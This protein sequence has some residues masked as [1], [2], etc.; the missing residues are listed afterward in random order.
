MRSSITLRFPMTILCALTLLSACGDDDDTLPATDA[1]RDATV[2]DLGSVDLSSVDLGYAD[3]GNVDLG[4]LDAGLPPSD[5]GAPSCGTARPTLTGVRGT[6]GLVIARDGTIYYS[7]SGGVGRVSIDGTNDDNWVTIAAA[8][9]VWGLALDASNATL[10]VASPMNSTIY[11]V[12]TAT[13]ASTELSDMLNQPNGLTM[14]PDGALYVGD[15][16]DDAVYRVDTASGATTEVTTSNVGSANGV[17]FAPGDPNTLYVLSYSAGTLTAL[18]LDATHMETARRMVAGS[19]G[20]P[21][22]I[23]LDDAGR[24][25]ITDNGAGRVIQLAADGTAPDVIST[26]A[27]GSAA[28]LAFGVG[29]LDCHD[30]YVT[31]S[32]VMVRIAVADATAAAV[33][34]Q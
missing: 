13:G 9:T 2:A 19:L 20:S 30:L 17:A 3:L 11:A 23:T 22:G 5:M 12:V 33:P 21:D 25:Y 24:F 6:E 14:G 16:G 27:I 1:G 29:A 28:N 10:Y 26:G 7:Q 34:W 31:S 8:S 4:G 18:T 15:F 32:G